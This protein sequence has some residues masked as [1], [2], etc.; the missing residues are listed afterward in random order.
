MRM[1][2]MAKAFERITLKGTIR[3]SLGTA[4]Q[5]SDELVDLEELWRLERESHRLFPDD[6]W[7]SIASELREIRGTLREFKQPLSRGLRVTLGEDPLLARVKAAQG[8]RR[9]RV[10]RKLRAAW[11]G[12]AWVR[13][14]GR[15]RRG[16]DSKQRDKAQDTGQDL[17]RGAG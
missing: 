5:V 10:L 7:K 4:H 15:R 17:E 1:D 12:L 2:A 9:Q 14:V 16:P 6:P 3:D 13:G 11:R 8:T